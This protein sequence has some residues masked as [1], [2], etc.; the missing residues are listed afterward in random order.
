ML[1]QTW[2]PWLCDWGS[3]N[4]KLTC[5]ALTCAG[6]LT[7]RPWSAAQRLNDIYK[8]YILQ[9]K[10]MCRTIANSTDIKHMFEKHLEAIMTTMASGS[11]T[12]ALSARIRGFQAARHRFAST[13][14]P[15]GRF[16][17]FFPAVVATALEL[18]VRRSNNTDMVTRARSFLENI[19]EE[20]LLQIAMLADAGDQASAVVRFFDADSFDVAGTRHTLSRFLEEID[21][22]FLQKAC[23]SLRLDDGSPACYTS[24]V[25][26]MLQTPIQITTY[27]AGRAVRRSIGGQ[28]TVSQDMTDTCLAHMAA[29]VRLTAAA[30]QGELPDWDVCSAFGVFDLNLN[31]SQS[32]K[33]VNQS[34]MRLAKT[35][36]CH[37]DRLEAQFQDFRKTAVHHKDMGKTNFD[38]WT[39][40]VVSQQRLRSRTA[41]PAAELL[42]VLA[43]YGVFIGGASTSSVERSFAALRVVHSSS[44][45]SLNAPTI[46]SD[47]RLK[48]FLDNVNSKSDTAALLQKKLCL[49][50]TK[51]WMATYP[52]QRSGKANSRRWTSGSQ[53]KVS[54]IS[55]ERQFLADRR[56]AVAIASS[57]ASSKR[58]VSDIVKSATTMSAEIWSETHAK[59]GAPIGQFS[60]SA[61]SNVVG[62]G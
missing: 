17:L 23:L 22:L 1:T 58:S 18:Q 24:Y 16:I 8:T 55:H 27:Q 60:A 14:K 40:S 4:H 49:Q 56:K 6:R 2:Q 43:V 10:S 41:H 35:F 28:T 3:L 34:L 51:V 32:K 29:W 46:E 37:P 15:L 53:K 38:A 12:L 36:D 47:L 21:T 9:S 42:N 44:R 50:A 54:K 45:Q 26:D 19:N 48:L 31:V 52:L 20:V 59:A 25:L 11:E 13:Q 39:A 33:F 7:K 61:E 57:K 62:I 5:T 30:V